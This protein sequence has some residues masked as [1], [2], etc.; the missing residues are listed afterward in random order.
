MPATTLFYQ[1]E[2]QTFTPRDY[3]QDAVDAGIAFFNEP[4]NKMGHAIEVLPTGSGKSLVI[5]LIIQGLVG[6]TIVLQPSKEILE[7]NF[8]KLQS[9]GYTAGIYSASLN[10]KE[11]RKITFATIGSV[12]KVTHL[13]EE[14]QHIIIDEC[15]LVNPKDGLYKSFINTLEKIEKTDNTVKVLG[16]TATPYR[17]A[18]NSYGSELRFITRTR[19][20]IFKRVIYYMNTK[21]LFAAGYLCPLKYYDMAGFDRKHLEMKA[22]GSGYTDES[23]EREYNK[24]N[25][26]A[27]LIRIIMRLVDKGEKHILVFTQLVKESIKLSRLFD[28][29]SYLCSDSKLVS[30]AQRVERIKKFKSGEIKIMFNVGVLAVGF[31]FPACAVCVIARPTMSLR[32][33][34]QWVGRI[35]RPHAS[36]KEGMVID[37]CGNIQQFGAIEDLTMEFDHNGQWVITSRGRQLTN[38]TFGEGKSAYIK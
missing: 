4:K 3:Q 9:Y 8:E 33:Y 17:L 28:H 35:M 36:K 12:A 14:F 37:L 25:L 22:N 7:Q 10:K 27:R 38:V 2:R 21:P 19:P 5:A 16:L 34:Y 20:R 15:D 31:D 1:P 6:K 13:F 32:S 30:A 26:E 23:V 18:S 11:V 24:S 29:A